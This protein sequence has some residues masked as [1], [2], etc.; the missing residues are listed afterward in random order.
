MSMPSASIAIFGQ[1]SLTDVVKG[2]RAT[3]R[4]TALFISAC[5]AEIKTEISSTDPQVKATALQK[6]T[7]LQMM[8]YDMSFASF[9]TIEV[10]SSIRFAHKRVGYLAASQGFNQNTEVILLTT[11]LLKKELR[12]AVG[13]GM[14]G[15]YDA[16]LAVNCLSNI[17]TEDLARELLPDLTNL[18]S[19]PQPY[20]RKKAVL[21]MF[22]LFA[23]VPARTEADVFSNSAMLGGSKPISG[24]MRR[25]R[26]YRTFRQKPK[27]LPSPRSGL[28][29]SVD[30]IQQQLDVD[31]G[32]QASRI[33]GSRR[34]SLSSKTTRSLWLALSRQHRPSHCSTK[35]STRSL[36]VCR[37]AEK[38]TGLCPPRSPPLLNSVQQHSARLLKILTKISNT[39]A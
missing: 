39:S 21:C 18:L 4:D 38:V 19:H 35:L 23:E 1:K 7:F 26:H 20:I 13:G 28:L 11:N 22:K 17:V 14:S 9:A 15:V 6:L 24:I 12:G 16:G 33:I 5:I 31:K 29:Q 2:I 34:A 36:F 30:F 8:G 10:M 32:S 37:T 25:Q 27:E 3:K